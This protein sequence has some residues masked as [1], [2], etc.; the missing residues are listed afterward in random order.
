[1]MLGGAFAGENVNI[2]PLQMDPINEG[3]TGVGFTVTVTVKLAPGQ[4]MDV[5]GVPV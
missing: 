2:S 3:I 1:M 5:V 4:G